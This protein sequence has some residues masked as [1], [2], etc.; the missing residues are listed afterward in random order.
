MPNINISDARQRDA[1]VKAESTRRNRVVFYQDDK[2]LPAYTRKVLKGAVHQD[3]DSMYDQFGDNEALAKALVDG[4]PEIDFERDGMFL[5]GTSR[6][7][8]NPKE[9][10]VYRIRT[11]E[12]VYNPDGSIRERREQRVLEANIDDEIP[13]TWT[14]KL[15]AKTDA[16]RQFVFATKLQIVHI[17]GLTY[18]FL[19]EM[20]KELHESK[21]LM[22]LGGGPKGKDPL[23]F[24]SRSLPFRGFLEGRIDGDKYILLLHLSNLELKKPERDGESRGVKPE[25]DSKS[26]SKPQTKSKTKKTKK[27][28]KKKTKTK[29][30]TKTKKPK[31]KAKAKK[32]KVKGA[33]NA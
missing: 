23:I 3:Y 22:I 16:I 32:T 24:R 17:N 11:E 28:K 15:I 31:A 1:V 12:V 29:T 5:W 2:G 7:Y 9:E 18:D 10:L 4:D 26:K 8:I 21:S 6:V 27:T 20:A 19:Y 14:G 33:K 25:K 13:L 30:K